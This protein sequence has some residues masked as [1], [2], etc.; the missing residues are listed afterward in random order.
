[1]S[2]QYVCQV[3]NKTYL[4]RKKLGAHFKKEPTHRM[5][6]SKEKFELWD[7]LV[8]IAKKCPE[9]Q[10]GRKFYKELLNL[11]N[12]IRALNNRLFKR[13]N[14]VEINEL[15]ANAIGLEPGTYY[16]ETKNLCKEGEMLSLMKKDYLTT[17]QECD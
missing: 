11:L 14:E 13:K 9:S 16:F 8:T 3:Y 1:M 6:E 7:H 2:A 5:Q 17:N 12:N 4:R 10:S 15:F